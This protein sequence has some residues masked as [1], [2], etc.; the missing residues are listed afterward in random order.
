[1]Y[2]NK[3]WDL[4]EAPKKIKPTRCKWVYKRKRVVYGNVETYKVR[5]VVKGYY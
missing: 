4:V 2:F 1:M 3:V 5:L